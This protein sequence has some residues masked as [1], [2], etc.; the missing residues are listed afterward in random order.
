MC[1][2]NSILPR[3]KVSIGAARPIFSSGIS[4]N[5]IKIAYLQSSQEPYICDDTSS[6]IAI[7]TVSLADLKEYSYSTP[8]I[9]MFFLYSTLEAFADFIIL[10]VGAYLVLWTPI[11]DDFEE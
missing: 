8:F 9:I 5:G 10:A 2:D 7:W 11:N 6:F 4:S 1:S 3:V